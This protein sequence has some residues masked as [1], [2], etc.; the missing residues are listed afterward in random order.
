MAKKTSEIRLLPPR[1]VPLAAAQ[2]DEAVLLLAELLLDAAEAK[3]RGIR[4]GGV[5]DGVS[6]G[7]LGSVVPFPERR[8]RGREVA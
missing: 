3:R 8:R 4:S 7:A 2:Y 5:I 6:G 1:R